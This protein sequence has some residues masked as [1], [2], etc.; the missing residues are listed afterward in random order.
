M[1]RRSSW[2]AAV[3]LLIAP[4]M[5][6]SSMAAQATDSQQAIKKLLQDKLQ[7]SVDSVS[8][9]PTDELL[10]AVTD[11]GILYV[12]KDGSKMFFG[13]VYQLSD[14]TNLTEQTMSKIRLDKLASFKDDM[15][16]FK[17]KDEQYVITV[18][19]DI[20]CGYCRKL[21]NQIAE[22]NDLGIT[23][24]YLAFPRGGLNSDSFDKLRDVWCSADQK[25]AMTKAKAGVDV[26]RATC[27]ADIAGQYQL[28]Q[29]FGVTGTPA[30]VLANGQMVPGY[31]PPQRLLNTLKSRNL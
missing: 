19:T 17:A 30:M 7:V 11:R 23:I 20:T 6:A 2:L 13:Q 9:G 3:T 29:T 4:F 10:E 31:I 21:H 24:Q 28:G 18:F 5:A 15:I 12:T 25:E 1:F 26:N 22:Y 8:Q 14:M 16:V 27:K